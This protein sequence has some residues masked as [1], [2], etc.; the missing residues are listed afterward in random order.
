MTD[1]A[2]SSGHGEILGTAAQHA[3]TTVP[4][5]AP[6]ETVDSLLT[7]REAVTGVMLGLLLAAL[8]FP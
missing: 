3:S 4:V 1:V 2:T 8:A 6:D 5:A 7:V